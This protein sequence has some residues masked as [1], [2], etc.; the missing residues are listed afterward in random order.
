MTITEQITER[1]YALG[2]DFVR[3]TVAERFAQAETAIKQRVGAG[4]FEG[5]DWFTAERAEVSSNPQA[6]LPAAR[7][8]ISLGTF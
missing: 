1:A 6:L 8:V 5:M 7:S 3:V 4:Y 2:F